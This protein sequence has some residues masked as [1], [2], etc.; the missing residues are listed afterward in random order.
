[1]KLK[2]RTIRGI[3]AA[4]AMLGM[5]PGAF[6]AVYTESFESGDFNGWSAGTINGSSTTVNADRASDGTYS[7][8]NSFAVLGSFGGWSTHTILDVDTRSIM[9]ENATTLTMDA[10]SDWANANNWGV[11]N[12]SINLILNYEGG[13]QQIGPASGGLSNGTF[14]TISFDLTP[15]A[16]TITD[17]GLGYSALSIVW[18]LG[19]W[20]GDNFGGTYTD[21]GT[22]T[23][24]IDNITITSV[25]EPS[26]VLLLGF[27]GIGMVLRRRR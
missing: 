10:Y 18:Q 26:S 2:S 27:C 6:A 11:Y 13:W 12:N 9:D 24:A 20:A 4:C 1:M 17:S 14:Q 8:G 16:A 19:T 5:M 23:F 7:A 22:Q 21:N 3:V 25:P 15:W